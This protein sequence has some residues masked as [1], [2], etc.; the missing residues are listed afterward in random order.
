M[1]ID[2]PTAN[3]SAWTQTI[4]GLTPDAN[5]LLSGW[6]RTEGVAPSDPAAVGGANLSLWGTWLSTRALMGTNDWTYVSLT[7]NSGPTGSVTAAARLGFWGAT[8]SGT[9]W[10]DD[11][12]VTEILPTDPHP[13]WDVLVLIYDRTDYGAAQP[14]GAHLGVALSAPQAR[15]QLLDQLRNDGV[16]PLGA[17]ERDGGDAAFLGLVEHGRHGSAG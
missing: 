14:D 1:R 2:A 8:A 7:F 6:I 16:E 5:Y 13:S 10:F 11:L 3:D 9:A 15:Q 17:V 12:R 4:T